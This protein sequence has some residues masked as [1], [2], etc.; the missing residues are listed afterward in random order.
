MP[1]TPELSLAE[2]PVDRLTRLRS[3]VVLPF[4]VLG[5]CLVTT[6]IS[7]FVLQHQDDDNAR[8]EF[9]AQARQS[10]DEIREELMGFEEVLQAG[11]ALLAA[12][13]T[14]S[15]DEWR[16]FIE[17]LDVPHMYP[18]IVSLNYA[19]SLEPNEIEAFTQR[20][21]AQGD[22][23]FKIWPEGARKEYAVIALVEPFGPTVTHA[24]GFD[25]MSEPTRRRA[26][27][28]ARDTGTV[29]MS[30]RVHLLPDMT[31]N[32]RPAILLFVPVYRRDSAPSSIAERRA[33][34]IGYV[35]AALHVDTVAADVLK[36][37]TL[38]LSL[39]IW[40]GEHT[41]PDA[42]VYSKESPRQDGLPT[43]SADVPLSFSGQTWTL[44]FGVRKSAAPIAQ[45]N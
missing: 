16:R 10:A 44:R 6:G 28:R 25:L 18:G 36:G 43:F 22:P 1:R 3:S 24:S 41:T 26:V 32:P 42:L 17:R 4:I 34:L 14:V 33:A 2:K 30:G 13:D 27:E 12:S 31:A 9:V 37:R 15:P 39:S 5:V 35:T 29:S 21:R 19:E 7:W 45:G 23:D 8:A 38:P 40:E 11:A 20:M